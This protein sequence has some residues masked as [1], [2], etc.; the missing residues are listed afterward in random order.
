MLI[1]LGDLPSI[2]NSVLL[3]TQVYEWSNMLLIIYFQSKYTLP[4]IMFKLSNKKS[5]DAYRRS[6]RRLRVYYIIVV[7]FVVGFNFYCL[8][9]RVFN[10]ELYS[11]SFFYVAVLK[12]ALTITGVL[13]SGFCLL[14]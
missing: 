1:I 9:F 14:S 12:D 13:L 5:R 11:Y 10:L 7:F 2:C 6:E 4:E 8:L 3:W